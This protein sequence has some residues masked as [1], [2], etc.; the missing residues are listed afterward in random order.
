MSPTL[1]PT[2]VDI[3]I[4]ISS[5]DLHSHI[6]KDAPEYPF[7]DSSAS[8]AEGA[9]PGPPLPKEAIAPKMISHATQTDPE[10]EQSSPH[11]SL[12]GQSPNHSRSSSHSRKSPS[13]AEQ[14]LNRLSGS[15]T[16]HRPT[17]PVAVD[18][19][20]RPLLAAPGNETPL[21]PTTPRAD[22]YKGQS[23][24][25]FGM[26]FEGAQKMHFRRVNKPAVCAHS[27]EDQKHRMMMDWLE[28]RV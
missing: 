28:R 9:G 13:W 18:A 11:I 2:L 6:E 26:T 24:A 16:N 14:L 1:P 17:A 23:E 12:R 3:P 4:I 5:P 22:L 27:Y 15:Q 10:D 20:G 7:T 19:S 21:R 25:N 8:D